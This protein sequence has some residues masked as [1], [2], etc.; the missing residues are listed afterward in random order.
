MLVRELIALLAHEDGG[1]EVLVSVDMMLSRSNP[2][3]G[4]LALPTRAIETGRFVG[5]E[6]GGHPWL[7]LVATD[8]WGI[9][10]KSPWLSSSKDSDRG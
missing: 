10:P 5:G 6:R 9:S 8:A 2:Q 4:V 7:A 3:P 1:A